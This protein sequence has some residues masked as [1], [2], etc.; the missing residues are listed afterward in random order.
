MVGGVTVSLATLHNEED[1][2]RKDIREGDTVIVQRAG[3][4]IPQVVGPHIEDGVKRGPPW[5]MPARCPV[6]DTPVV[7]PEGE[8]DAPLPE[9]E[10]PGQGLRVAQALR[11]PRRDGHRRRRREA[12]P[13]AA[14]RAA[15]RHAARPLPAD[16]R[17]PAGAGRLPGAVGRERD[18]VDRGVEGAAVRRTSCS[19][20]ASRTSAPSTPQLL[21]D[22]FGSIDAL[23]A[24][25]PRGDRRGRGHRPGDRRGG[26][27]LARRRGSPGG[28]RRPARRR[29]AP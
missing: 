8:V 25:R 12:D 15:D 9:P 6:C 20:S 14:G 3:D 17:R 26:R 29:R 19:R 18:R 23:E 1:I 24:A 10:L 5:K 16:G 22:H 13:P 7:K 2:N 21:A 4:V 27:R 11:Q 28:G